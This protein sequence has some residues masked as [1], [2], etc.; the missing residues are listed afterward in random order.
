LFAPSTATGA[1]NNARYVAV[2]AMFVFCVS[3]AVLFK[4][5]S[6]RARGRVLRKTLEAAAAMYYGN[7]LWGLLPL[8]QKVSM[9][10]CVGW[11][12][13]LQLTPGKRAGDDERVF[14]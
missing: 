3:V 7:M 5:V 13:T 9:A 11:L 2:L 10:A 6:R 14:S 8:A 12:L 1:T 4:L